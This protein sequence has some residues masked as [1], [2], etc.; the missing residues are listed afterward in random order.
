MKTGFIGR[1]RELDLLDRAWTG[2]GSAL[3]PIYGR[4]RV[5]KSELILRALAGRPGVYCSGKRAPPALQIREFLAASAAAWNEPL[6][7]SAA[8]EDWKTALE[9]VAG[10]APEGRW[11]LALDEFQW[12]AEASPELPS[13]LQEL[14]DRRWSRDGRVVLILCGSYLGFME[15][16]I[17]GRR[18]P[19]FGRRT[20]QIRLAPFDFRE[21]AAFHPRYSREDQ[22]RLHTV[23]GGIPWYLRLVDPDRS[24]AD[25]LARLLLDPL[26][27]LFAEPDFLLREELRELENYNAILMAMA[28]GARLHADIARQTGMSNR[29]LHYYLQQLIDLGYAVRRHPLTGTP[30]GPRQVRFEVGDPLLR[31]WFR[32]VYPAQSGI[33]QSGPARA[34]RERVAPDFESFVGGGFERLCR[35]ALPMQYA[36]EGVAAGF[37]VGEYWDREVQIDVV[38]L[39]QDNW[40]DLGECKWGTVRSLPALRAELEA[41]VPRFPNRRGATVGHRLFVRHGPVAGREAPA[42]WRIHDLDDLYEG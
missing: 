1:A 32:Y 12:M 16:E 19:L 13:I 29:A 40:T 22:V 7:A 3:I 9:A 34:Y 42:G 14:W 17:L 20:G 27:P 26:G 18:S 24:V 38:G 15:R 31:F 37:E 10:R 2:P 5:G 33:V 41:K 8:T 35:E 39:R 30:P 6:L 36:R 25:N 11:M 23:L 4:R 21:A 28:G